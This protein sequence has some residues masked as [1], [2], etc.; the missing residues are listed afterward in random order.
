MKVSLTVRTYSQLFR[1][2]EMSRD[3]KRQRFGILLSTST[4]VR[5]TS[6]LS[7]HVVERFSM[8]RDKVDRKVREK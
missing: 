6:Q 1:V 8:L 2:A 5:I 4:Q 3:Q 7:H